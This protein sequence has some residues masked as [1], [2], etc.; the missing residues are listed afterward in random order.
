MADYIECVGMSRTERSIEK[1]QHLRW[2][3]AYNA[4]RLKVESDERRLD[5]LVK[6]D[7]E[8]IFKLIPDKAFVAKYF[9]E[10]RTDQ[11]RMEG[12]RYKFN[13]PETDL[14]PEV[15]LL[16]WKRDEVTGEEKLVGE[17]GDLYTVELM[18]PCG[19]GLSPSTSLWRALSPGSNTSPGC[20][21]RCLTSDMLREPIRSQARP[22]S[23]I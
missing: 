20:S 10:E 16:L 5:E 15:T 6:E 9:L 14:D 8:K 1:A 22:G 21:T 7:E 4:A 23:P 18:S 3:R 19:V 13:I 17:A 12:L 2:K 11:M